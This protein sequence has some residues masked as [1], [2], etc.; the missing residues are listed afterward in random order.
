[1]L[2]PVSDC[3]RVKKDT[4]KRQCDYGLIDFVHSSV[5]ITSTKTSYP[6]HIALSS[7]AAAPDGGDI[8]HGYPDTYSLQQGMCKQK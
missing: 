7:K 8:K 3:K 2:Y 6:L 4:K 1:M 5:K